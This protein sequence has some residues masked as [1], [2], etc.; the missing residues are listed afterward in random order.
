MN[1]YIFP[2][3]MG[4]AGYVGEDRAVIVRFKSSSVGGGNFTFVGSMGSTIIRKLAWLAKGVCRRIT[5]WF[6]GS[7]VLPVM[8]SSSFKEN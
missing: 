5:D 2:K 8:R 3:L 7:F 4:N 1:L 6:G